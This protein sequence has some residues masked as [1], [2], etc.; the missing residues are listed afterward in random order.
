MPYKPAKWIEFPLRNISSR[1]NDMWQQQNNRET[2]QNGYENDVIY[3]LSDR[4]PQR[5]TV[6][7]KLG[8]EMEELRAFLS[9]RWRKPTLTGKQGDTSPHMD[10][11][12]CPLSSLTCLRL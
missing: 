8:Q 11:H 12:M 6:T 10:D 2:P 4:D 7:V 9:F 3:T 1:D 5:V